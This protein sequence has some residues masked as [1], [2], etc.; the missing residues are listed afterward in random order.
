MANDAIAYIKK[1]LGGGEEE[2]LVFC[3][4]GAT[5]A[6]KRL[7]EVMG[8]AVPSI[9]RDRVIETLKEE[10]RWVVFVGPYE[11]HSNLL[12]W[13]QSLAEVVEIGMDENGVLDI[14]MLRSQLEA[15]KKAGKR[16][17]LGSFSACSNVTG[18][19]VDTKAIATLIHEYGGHVCFD[20]AARYL[21]FTHLLESKAL[22]KCLTTM[23]WPLCANRYAI[24]GN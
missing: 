2:A 11:H 14:E 3:G 15:Y 8:I 6:I 10:E 18:I 7:Q 20:F 24:R 23:Q 16:Q 21:N 19:Y 12:S 13:G 17:I 22:A 4:Q 9:L 1:C 5:S